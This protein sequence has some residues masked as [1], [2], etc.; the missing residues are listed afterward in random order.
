MRRT[1]L[2]AL[3]LTSCDGEKLP[4]G[5][6][7]GGKR[8]DSPRIEPAKVDIEAEKAKLAAERERLQQERAALEQEKMALER[9]RQET[10]QTARQAEDR[11]TFLKSELIAAQAYPAAADETSIIARG[12]VALENRL[13]TTQ[14]PLVTNPKRPLILAAAVAKFYEVEPNGSVP[15]SAE[16]LASVSRCLAIIKGNS[17]AAPQS[18]PPRRQI[19]GT[20]AGAV[21]AGLSPEVYNP[22]ESTQ[23]DDIQATL[24]AHEQQ[25]L[26]NENLERMKENRERFNEFNRRK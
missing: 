20:I 10:S 22:R 17:P 18:P 19:P 24:K 7:S 26:L 25:R 8:E 14:D 6:L 13:L 12:M 11:E 3:I 15:L 1:V 21:A 2:L 16:D 23:L 4:S 5:Q 9:N